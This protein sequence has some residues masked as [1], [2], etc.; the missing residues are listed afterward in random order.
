MGF[1]GGSRNTVTALVLSARTFTLWYR[2][3]APVT[4]DR[5]GLIQ[6]LGWNVENIVNLNL[7]IFG[8]ND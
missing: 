5:D 8:K 4:T 1:P 7:L 2:S 6:I 3:K